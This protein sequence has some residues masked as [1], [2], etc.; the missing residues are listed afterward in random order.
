VNSNS[1]YLEEFMFRRVS[2]A[3]GG[4]IAI[5]SQTVWLDLG[6]HQGQFLRM[7]LSRF[8]LRGVGSDAWEPHLKGSA[9]S[10]WT[11]YQA[12]FEKFLPPCG[13][14]DVVSALEVLEHMID[15]DLFLKRIHA[16]LRP[17]GLV[18]IST[19]NI[20]SF[21]NRMTVPLGIYPTGL[22]YRNLIHHVRLYNAKVLRQQLFE[23]GFCDVE[24]RGVA[25]LPLS[26]RFGVGRT[27]QFLADNF[28]SFCTDLLAVARKA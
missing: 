22:E 15:T 13:P 1:E 7:L 12:D 19:P 28:P 9:D 18:L 6:C 23:S 27:S 24:I 4:K 25:F 8:G 5:N 14:V 17:N 20:N 11:Y 16:I 10:G 3:L 21:R 2:D 26:S